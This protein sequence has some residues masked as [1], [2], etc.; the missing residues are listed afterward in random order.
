MSA[1]CLE[2]IWEID[3]AYGFEGTFL[4]AYA[5]AATKHLRYNGFAIFEVDGFNFASDLWTKSVTCPIAAS[6]LALVQ[7][8]YGNSDL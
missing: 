6:W 4:D 1:F 5:A 7:V 2:L 8:N 3:Y